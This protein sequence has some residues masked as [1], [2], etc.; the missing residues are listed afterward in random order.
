MERYELHTC[1]NE[2][3][4]INLV[5]AIDETVITERNGTWVLVLQYNDQTGFEQTDHQP[6]RKRDPIERLDLEALSLQEKK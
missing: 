2:L 5:I 1:M 3:M 4:A 6:F